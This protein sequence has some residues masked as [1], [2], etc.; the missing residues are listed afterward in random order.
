MSF[1]AGRVLILSRASSGKLCLGSQVC[2]G[3]LLIQEGRIHGRIAEWQREQE[4]S[5]GRR[6]GWAKVP[7]EKYIHLLSLL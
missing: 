7:T 4:F 2:R 1:L 6:A 5:M 3:H